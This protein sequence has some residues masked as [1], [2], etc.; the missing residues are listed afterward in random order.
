MND[1]WRPDDGH[2]RPDP[3]WRIFMRTPPLALRL[4]AAFALALAQLAP[5]VAAQNAQADP[6]R[7]RAFALFAEQ[8]F[9]D[10][11]ARP[12][13]SCRRTPRLGEI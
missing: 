5:A 3:D 1:D 13:R 2:G 8:K 6:E 10:A 7:G 11:L 9:V 4:A 12:W